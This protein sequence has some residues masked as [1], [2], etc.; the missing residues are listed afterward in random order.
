MAECTSIDALVTPYIDGEL[1]S[2]ACRA[3]ERHLGI[4]APCRS[5]VAAERAV[6]ALLRERK[7]S[8]TEERAPLKVRVA[9]ASQDV[10]PDRLPDVLPASSMR[11]PLD[12][13]P[14]WRS[15]LVPLGVAAALVAVVGGAFLVQLTPSSSRLMV[16]ELAADHVKCFAMNAVLRTHEATEAVEGSMASGFSWDMR[17]P[18]SPEREGLELVGSRPCLYGGGKIAH[19]MYRYHGRPVSLFMLPRTTRS[20]QLVD[21]LG[22][23]AAIWSVD[24]RTFVLIA[25][26]ARSEVERMAAFVHAALR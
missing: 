4:C 23:E 10:Q 7:A 17:L 6:V 11:A 14:T 9:C 21:V 22:H 5:R 15:R 24:D 25:R 3:V 1:E 2:S 26:E 19:I 12:A 16:A 18:E 8:L 13:R 20:E